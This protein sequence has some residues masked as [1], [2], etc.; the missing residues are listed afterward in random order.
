MRNKKRRAKAMV[1]AASE[2][3]SLLLSADVRML[4]LVAAEG[5]AA[6]RPTF[7]ID[8]YNGGPMRIGFSKPVV[9]DLSGLR[10]KS[11][12]PVL[13]DHDAS[14]IVGQS[15]SAKIDNGSIRLEGTVTGDDDIARKV[16]SHAKNGFEWSASIGVAI[17]KLESVDAQTT[18]S[19]N[20]KSFTGPLY[21]VRA[22]RLGEVSFV[23][24]G[25]DET[26]TARVAAKHAGSEETSMNPFEDWLSAN[27]WDAESLT[28]SQLSSLKIA[29]EASIKAQE[30]GDGGGDSVKAVRA[31]AVRI[32][33][34]TRIAFR[35]PEILAKAVSEGWTSEKAEY[36]V[37]LASYKNA[38]SAIIRDKGDVTPQVL[39]ASIRMQCAASSARIEKEYPEKVLDLATKSR[40]MGL[41]ALIQSAMACDGRQAP[42]LTA[43]MNEWVRA[44]FS[45]ATLPSILSNSANKIMQDAFVAVSRSAP[46]VTKKLSSNDFKV[47][48]GHRLLGN[49]LMEKV[50][51]GG[52][53]KHDSLTETTFTFQ[54]D[55]YMDIIALTRQQWIN[56][57]MGAFTQIPAM[58]GRRA[59][60]TVENALWSLVIA[61]TENFFHT[62]NS[63][64]ISGA[65]SALGVAGL[66]AAVAAMRKF[67]DA[68]GA[69]IMAQP[70]FLVVPPE[71]EAEAMR[72]FGSDVLIATG[73]GSSAKTAASANVWRGRFQ[74]V[75]VPH[76]TSA[77]EWYLFAD[78][79]DVAAF[80]ICYLNGV[81]SP[82]IE[83]VDLPPQ[84]L[85]M[86]WRGYIDFGVCQI[87]KQGA[88]KSAGS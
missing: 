3:R 65:S 86:A 30:G 26:A 5:A 68:R 72:L 27:G 56:D 33:A 10:M 71:L 2:S 8:A 25:A 77:A 87:D 49:A 36:E 41:K 85:G 1:R 20:G 47:H 43:D 14:Q 70:K 7:S 51:P 52:E 75:A 66:D 19:V 13:L 34:V 24:I 78:P 37:K 67:T 44:G 15:T 9:I 88:V 62:N 63:N 23:S 31:E 42:A 50:G 4:D 45:T 17:D 83:E 16:V 38:P 59:A 79:A 29:H 40:R 28:T 53:A 74:P 58:I 12:I 73:V 81:E 64:I 61:N 48:T 60:L 21:V 54:A 39:E 46:M 84:Y 6:K 82:T 32:A 80:G 22:G 55:T 69:P 11:R 57:D 35:E 18:V 76:L